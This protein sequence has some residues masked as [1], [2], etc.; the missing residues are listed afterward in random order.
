MVERA[1][2]FCATRPI[3]WRQ[4]RRHRNRV[5]CNIVLVGVTFLDGTWAYR[6][7]PTEVIVCD[8][9]EILGE[10]FGSYDPKGL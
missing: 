4:S 8:T 10:G 7:R 2:L 3:P 6:R 9:H 1:L 5:L